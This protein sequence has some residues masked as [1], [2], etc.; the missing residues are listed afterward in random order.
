M[1]MRKLSGI[2]SKLYK[3][4]GFEYKISF[5]YLL[6]S[7]LWIFFSDRFLIYLSAEKNTL[8]QYQTIKG[9]AFVLGT[10]LM[11]FFFIRK[12][13]RKIN[14][15]KRKYRE[16]SDNWQ[17]TFNAISDVVMLLDNDF[18]IVQIN[19]AGAKLANTTR[20]QLKGRFCHTVMH[21]KAGLIGKC[22]G[23]KSKL[24][25]KPE[26]V[27]YRIDDKYYELSSWPIFNEENEING[28]AHIVKDNTET[29]LNREKI[30]E[31]NVLFETMFA[32][33]P[34]AILLTDQNDIITLSNK[35]AEKFL[36]YDLQESELLTFRHLLFENTE[37]EAKFHFSTF[38]DDSDR[39][40]TSYYLKRNGDYFIGETFYAK[41]LGAEGEQFG[42]IYYI[43]DVSERVRY[44]KDLDHAKNAAEESDQLKTRFLQNLSHE[45]RTPLNAI[46]G[47]SQI[48]GREETG[49]DQQKQYAEIIHNAG[50]RLIDNVE[51]TLTLALLQT[52]QIVFQQSEFDVAP[53]VKRIYQDY[54]SS[55]SANSA[56]S[57]NF[58]LQIPPDDNT[59]LYSDEGYIEQ[60]L[61]I[62]LNNS[63]KFTK[64]GKIKLGYSVTA[65]RLV[66]FVKDT[67]SGMADKKLNSAMK[68]FS[69][70]DTDIQKSFGGMGLGLAIAHELVNK[71][72]GSL[73]INSE[74]GRGT[75]IF[76]TFR[77]TTF[78]ELQNT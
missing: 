76:V 42:N 24:T 30:A 11:L 25:G 57:V 43:R 6:I 53:L 55:N 47:F 36:G 74:V 4:I 14:T 77:L 39:A 63:F 44:I 70:A 29:I 58:I 69:Q 46:I 33:V 20:E 32:T 48:Q 66:F 56:K 67:G 12:H 64:E 72:S 37:T 27:E 73:S 49:K 16:I 75:D 13:N 28:F 52:E 21:H 5:L 54:L 40:F 26:S 8:S 15:L 17:T 38:A 59:V 61:R 71:L 31:Q 50:M 51:N 9:M 2:E 65:D 60:I 41:L 7:A 45:I 18:E 35:A 3:Q 68:S 10:A 19:E 62:F 34:N 1:I 78:S 22:P 23:I